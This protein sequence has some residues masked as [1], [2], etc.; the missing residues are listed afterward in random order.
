MSTI[1]FITFHTLIQSSCFLR[2][3]YEIVENGFTT[4]PIGKSLL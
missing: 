4:F 1:L 2:G 3:N